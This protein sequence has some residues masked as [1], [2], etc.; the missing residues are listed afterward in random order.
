MNEGGRPAA[1][2]GPCRVDHP[3]GQS[4]RTIG[5]LVH[6][7]AGVRARQSPRQGGTQLPDQFDDLHDRD[8]ISRDRLD[9][10][11]AAPRLRGLLDRHCDPPDHS[12]GGRQGCGLQPEHPDFK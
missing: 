11:P 12:R 4:D 9:R 2:F 10:S 7:E 8:G 6:Q 3:A 1:H 5:V